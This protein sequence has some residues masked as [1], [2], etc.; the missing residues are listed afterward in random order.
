MKH[1]LKHYYTK[2]AI[3]N[4]FSNVY[5][6]VDINNKQTQGVKNPSNSNNS[7]E[8]PS[9]F[10]MADIIEDAQ[11]FQTSVKQEYMLLMTVLI[12]SSFNRRSYRCRKHGKAYCAERLQKTCN[13]E[14]EN[15]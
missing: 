1:Y 6:T 8:L 15:Y 7:G 13:S 9:V 14:K 11:V 3:H 4:S 10:K 2:S 5:N 12:D